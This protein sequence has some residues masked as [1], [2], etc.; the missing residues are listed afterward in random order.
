MLESRGQCHARGEKQGSLHLIM[1]PTELNEYR[2]RQMKTVTKSGVEENQEHHF[3]PH[4]RVCMRESA[5]EALIKRR[6]FVKKKGRART[7]FP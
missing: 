5:Y 1:A 6:K 4:L 2:E 7:M 3:Q